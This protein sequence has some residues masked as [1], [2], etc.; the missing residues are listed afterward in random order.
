MPRRQSL[1]GARARRL[2][3][4]GPSVW[5]RATSA[6]RLQDVESDAAKQFLLAAEAVDDIP[7]GIT[8]SGDVF[9]KYKL[10][11]DGVVLL[12]K[13]SGLPSSARGEVLRGGAPPWLLPENLAHSRWPSGHP[14]PAFSPRPPL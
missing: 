1:E 11:R 9:S 14:G 6:S 12:K 4:A 7:F 5:A 10:D 13:V 3:W 8:S 2:V